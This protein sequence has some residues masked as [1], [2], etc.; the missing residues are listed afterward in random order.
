VVDRGL[1]FLEEHGDEPFFLYMQFWDPHTPYNR[2]SDEVD[3]FDDGYVPPYPTSEQIDDH[4]DWDT[5]RSAGTEGVADREDLA[6]IL[7]RYD[8]EINYV[9]DQ[10]GRLVGYLRRE[11]LYDET[12][13]VVTADHGEE[14]GEHGLYREHWSTHEGTQHVPLLV[15]PPADEPVETGPREHLVTNV[16]MAPTLADYAGLDAPAQWQGRSIRPVVADTG[17]PGRDRIVVDHGLYTA[18]RAVRTDRW[19][20]VR[21]YEDGLWDL[22]DRQ[23]FDMQGDP[24]EQENVADD[25]PDVVDELETEMV[26]W[27]ERHRGRA[28]DELHAVAREGP[29]GLNWA[30]DD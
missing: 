23:L 11:G 10:L 24:W 7:A 18:Q 19:K 29:A 4:R 13:L 5:W 28:E 27:A 12:L 1:S 6:R 16:D 17:A 8:A 2:S 3:A 9:D 30:T 26:E 15:K 25:Y 22:P 14:F 21:T 20:F